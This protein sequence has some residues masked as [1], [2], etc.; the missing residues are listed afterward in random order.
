MKKLFLFPLFCMLALFTACKSTQPVAESNVSQSENQPSWV[1]SRPVINDYYIGIGT[2]RKSST[3]EN[4]ISIA[5][6]NALNDLVSEIS[7]RV[8]GKTQLYQFENR[9]E[10]KEEFEAY[11]NTSI[12]ESLEGYELVASWG[13]D[14]EYWVYYKLSKQLYTE[15]KARKLADI[16]KRAL[17]Y[18]ESAKDYEEKH[19]YTNALSFY[20]KAFDVLKKNLSDDLTTFS[21]TAGSVN[22]G[23]EIFKSVQNIVSH[24][25][26]TPNTDKISVNL[27]API[28]QNINVAAFFTNEKGEAF[29]VS[30]L[31]LKFIFSKGKSTLNEILSTNQEGKSILTTA[32]VTGKG[33]IQQIQ[34][35]LDI[36][37]VMGEL[38][39]E[40]IIKQLFSFQ[41]SL[42]VCKIT[43]EVE[44]KKAFMVIE[45]SEFEK[46]STRKIVGQSFKKEL[47][48]KLFSFSNEESKADL[49]VKI[50]TKSIKGPYLDK[51]DLYVVYMDCEISVWD[52]KTQSEVYNGGFSDLKGMQVRSYEN[53]LKDAWDKALEKFKTE[54]I[55]A[56]ANTDL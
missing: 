30:N 16:K 11:I 51:N 12:K 24:I 8:S 40:N 23:T 17:N 18:Y 32:K 25:R 54:I 44:G 41:S 10:L 20:L 39:K 29:P 42:P 55:P 27:S 34:A 1:I 19:D 7:I 52:N 14:Q 47:S 43:V 31:P 56:M 21:P 38:E 36:P 2:A 6:N 3:S 37:S 13:N 46:P 4:H 26:L 49:T 15:I 45:E 35:M 50:N 33:K 5:R 28:Q 9:K 22:L 48:E 53:A